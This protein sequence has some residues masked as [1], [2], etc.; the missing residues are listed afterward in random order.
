MP[1]QSP[2]RWTVKA[3]TEVRD[4]LRALRRTDPDVYQAVGPE[5]PEGAQAS[6]GP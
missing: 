4:W 1:A 2:R 6:I 5:Q 3:T